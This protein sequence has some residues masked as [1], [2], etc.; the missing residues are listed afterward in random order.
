MKLQLAT[1]KQFKLLLYCLLHVILPSNAFQ[2]TY[3]WKKRQ[4]KVFFFN[5]VVRYLERQSITFCGDKDD[6][7]SN[8]IQLLNCMLMMTIPNSRSAYVKYITWY[9]EWTT[10]NNSP[11]STKGS[12]CRCFWVNIFL[13]NVW[14]MHRLF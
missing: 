1:K 9:S 11:F 2:T 13:C 12:S 14:L 10:P 8:F 6:S 5:F 7:N 3:W 4:K